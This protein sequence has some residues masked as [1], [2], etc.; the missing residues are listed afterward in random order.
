MLADNVLVLQTGI[1]GWRIN[2]YFPDSDFINRGI[3]GQITGEMLARMKQDV[4]DLKPAAVLILAGTNDIGRG[5]ALTD[6]KSV[7]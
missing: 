7:V 1:D 6:R 5:T 2:E 3:S 4:I